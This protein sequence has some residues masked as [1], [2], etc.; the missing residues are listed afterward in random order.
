MQGQYE[1]SETGLY[2]NTFRYYDPEIGRFISQDPIGLAGGNNL[3]QFAPNVNSW[4]DP[5]GLAA[6]TAPFRFNSET[7]RWHGPNG[8]FV[9]A[10]DA[11]QMR[12]WGKSQGWQNTHTTGAGFET[13]SDANGQKR[14]KIKPASTQAGLHENSQRPRV[15][16]WDAT[17]Q[18]VDGF[19]R[20]V[21]KKS[22][23]AHAPLKS[24]C[25]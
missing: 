21:T 6:N 20:A 14:M 1:D 10:P 13:W 11:N 5:W 24:G 3:Y 18:R 12:D 2:Y 19:G 23:T 7:N 15:S 22:V 8:R 9:P 16:I 17:G 4:I 25:I